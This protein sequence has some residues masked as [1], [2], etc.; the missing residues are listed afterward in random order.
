MNF[1]DFDKTKNEVINYLFEQE[2]FKHNVDKFYRNC[3]TY[4]ELHEVFMQDYLQSEINLEVLRT[5]VCI[6][7]KKVRTT[8]PKLDGSNC[9]TL[10]SLLIYMDI[11][12][13]KNVFNTF[14]ELELIG[15]Y[16]KET[17]KELID[18]YSYKH[19]LKELIDLN[20]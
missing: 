9:A 12:E 2:F 10:L 7:P 8:L 1:S 17:I 16:D 13:A 18:N 15:V 5:Y 11:N 3:K 19:M 14:V 4:S 20:C 6:F